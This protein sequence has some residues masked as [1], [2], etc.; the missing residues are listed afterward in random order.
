MFLHMKEH[1]GSCV[2]RAR[3][4]FFQ[5]FFYKHW[6][7]FHGLLNFFFKQWLLFFTRFLCEPQWS[8]TTLSCTSWVASEIQPSSEPSFC[9][10]F[11]SRGVV[12]TSMTATPSTKCFSKPGWPLS[13]SAWPPR[14]P[15]E[16]PGPTKT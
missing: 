16:P 6:L 9:T 15:S 3:C 14:R 5:R 7:L 8:C 1:L 4:S 12:S 2:E 13:K 10:T 11:G